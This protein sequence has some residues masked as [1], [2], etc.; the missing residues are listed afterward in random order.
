MLH[1]DLR[2]M[3]S[4]TLHSDILER[5]VCLHL[6]V[7]RLFWNRKYNSII[8]EFLCSKLIVCEAVS[9]NFSCFSNFKSAVAQLQPMIIN[10]S[11]W[12]STIAGKLYSKLFNLLTLVDLGIISTIFKFKNCFHAFT[13]H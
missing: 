5:I 9:Y 1:V 13:K 4:V 7:S 3:P 6:L 2:A 11:F 8:S 12:E 10:T